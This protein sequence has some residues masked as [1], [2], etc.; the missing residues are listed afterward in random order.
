MRVQEGYNNW[1][2]NYD[3]DENLT[4]D[5]DREATRKT[6]QEAQ[7]VSILEVG[8]GT[9]KNTDFLSRIGEKVHALDFSIR[10]MEKAQAKVAGRNVEFALADINAEWPCESQAYDLVVC[11]LVLEHIENLNWVFSEARRVLVKKGQVYICELHPYQQYQGKKARF[12]KEKDVI[13]IPAYLH[14]ISE[15]LAAGE[16]NEFGII[17]LKEWWH[18]E[19]QGKAPRLVS[20]MFEK[21]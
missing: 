7:F 3:T 11:N 13:E 12:E 6:F 20:I 16:K 5:L 9:G 10:M 14:H 1:S 19:D 15:Y 4:R 8:C 18:A 2:E 21:K 17:S